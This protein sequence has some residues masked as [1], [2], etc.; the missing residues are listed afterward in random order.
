MKWKYGMIKVAEDEFGE[1][2][3]DVCEIVEVFQSESEEYTSFSKPF[4]S[5]IE[6]LNIAHKDINRDGINTWFYDN[7]KFIWKE[8]F[9]FWDWKKNDVDSS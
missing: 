7:G 3:D 1:G 2:S 8:E 4:L 9:N 6:D 5:S